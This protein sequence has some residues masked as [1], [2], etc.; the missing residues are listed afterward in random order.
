MFEI[1]KIEIVMDQN[2]GQKIDD[3]QSNVVD[4]SPLS[5]DF[6]LKNLN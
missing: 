2:H 3:Q 1:G 4:F 6:H 5:N